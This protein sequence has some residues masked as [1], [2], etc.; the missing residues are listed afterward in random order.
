MQV[1]GKQFW[2]GPAQAGV[3]VTLWADTDVIHL[4]IAGTRVKVG[5]LTSVRERSGAAGAAG[6]TG[7]RPPSD[8]LTEA[9]EV[10]RTVK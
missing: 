5:A 6:W 9:V 7:S 4:L 8:G 2:I 3:T 10:H 1:A